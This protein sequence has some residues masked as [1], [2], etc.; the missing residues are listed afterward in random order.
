MRLI[1]KPKVIEDS[2]RFPRDVQDA[3]RVW[4]NVV[5]KARWRHLNDVR[6]TYSRSVDQVEDFLIFNIKTHRLLVGFNF[7]KQIIYYK[8]LLTHDEYE[9]GKWRNDPYFKS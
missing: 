2:E 9:A 3:V 8:Y 4:C 7:E 6:E 1:K 5:K